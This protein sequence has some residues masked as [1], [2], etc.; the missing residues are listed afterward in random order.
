MSMTKH[1]PREEYGRTL[2]E[3]AAAT[4]AAD[5]VITF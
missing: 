4:L 5:K 3:L 2:V 1:N